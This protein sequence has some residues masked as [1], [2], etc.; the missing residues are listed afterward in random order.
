MSREF[1]KKMFQE[2]KMDGFKVSF[3]TSSPTQFEPCLTGWKLTMLCAHQCPYT[4]CAHRHFLHHRKQ[5]HFWESNL[6]HLRLARVPV[7]MLTHYTNPPPHAHFRTFLH[8]PAACA[9]AASVKENLPDFGPD[10]KASKLYSSSNSI[11]WNT[12]LERLFWFAMLGWE[13]F[14]GIMLAGV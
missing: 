5:T 4:G 11:S 1:E 13:S 3:L 14:Y 2:S 7:K 6:R 12:S 9:L 8:A 10:T